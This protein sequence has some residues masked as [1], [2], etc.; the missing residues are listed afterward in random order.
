[1]VKDAREYIF[2]KGWEFK[3]SGKN[4]ILKTCPYCGKSDW[5][6]SINAEN[7]VWICNHSSSCGE[8]GNLWRIQRDQGDISPV[9]RKP[10]VK[11][12]QIVMGNNVSPFHQWYESVRGIKAD[13]LEKYGVGYVERGGKKYI[14]YSCVDKEGEILNRKYRNV[15]DKSD[16]WTEKNAHQAYYGLQFVD[17]E[18]QFLFVVEGEDDCHAMAQYGIGNVVSI[19]Y[20]SLSYSPEMDAINKRFKHILTVFDNDEKG[21]LGARR[22]AEK[23]GL[24]KCKNAMLPFKDAR[25]CLLNGIDAEKFKDYLSKAEAFKYEKIISQSDIFDRWFDFTFRTEGVAATNIEVEAINRILGGIR[26]GEVSM[27]TGHSG[28]GKSTFAYNLGH[29]CEKAS[30][31]VFCMSFENKL[32][33]VAR[34]FIE[35]D[36]SQSIYAFNEETRSYELCVDENW[37][38]LMRRNF[39]NRSIWHFDKDYSQDGFF[40]VSTVIES[41]T[42]ANKFYDCNFIIVDHLHY[43]LKLSGE[44]NPSDKISECVRSLSILAQKLGVHIAIIVHPHKTNDRSGRLEKL[45]MNSAK[46]SSGIVQESDNY[47]IVERP[48]EDSISIVSIV[49]NREIGKL[50]KM[51]FVVLDNGNT[52]VED[53]QFDFEAYAINNTKGKV[54]DY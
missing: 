1:M 48:G 29:W 4:L 52:F 7:G 44:R 30:L 28:Q 2:A 24:N 25:D 43:F 34:K 53:K 9:Y 15:K 42:Y 13:I 3:E 47:L 39:E 50:G 5:K 49:K 27:I 37:A 32:V 38:T 20:G 36:S 19:P 41:I 54:G 12:K 51:A 14:V 31:N 10:R 46:G 18:K 40:D 33:N 6:F 26:M 23:A 45:T 17:F 21:Q 16:M 11:P 35:I 22:F 8:R